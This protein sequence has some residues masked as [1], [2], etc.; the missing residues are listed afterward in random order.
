MCCAQTCV[1]TDNLIR[2]NDTA[3]PRLFPASA[4]PSRHS[5]THVLTASEVGVLSFSVP[6]T[7]LLLY[8]AL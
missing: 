8:E 7:F 1:F 2:S 5:K 3:R 6:T 4:F